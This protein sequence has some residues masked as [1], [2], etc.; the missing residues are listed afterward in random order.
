MCNSIA[1]RQRRQSREERR[2][3]GGTKQ[4]RETDAI[5][6]E[7]FLY[8]HHGSSLKFMLWS[9]VRLYISA[10]RKEGGWLASSLSLAKGKLGG[11]GGKR[12]EGGG[13]IVIYV[14]KN[15][16]GAI[17]NGDYRENGRGERKGR[18][19]KWLE[20]QPRCKGS[21]RGKGGWMGECAT[22]VSN[23]YGNNDVYTKSLSYSF[24]STG[25]H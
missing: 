3:T 25:C 9:E 6:I 24:F 16:R 19:K 4:T 15:A 21:F 1:K 11:V 13:N 14:W 20:W 2:G 12:G 23:A 5:N 22:R 8:F 17:R 18:M 10:R 7:A